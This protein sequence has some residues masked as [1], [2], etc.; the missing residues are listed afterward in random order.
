MRCAHFELDFSFEASTVKITDIGPAH[1]E[2]RTSLGV[3]A[4]RIPIAPGE[5][6]R[7]NGEG[8]L[9]LE[10]W[11]YR[12]DTTVSAGGR[13]TS[14]SRDGLPG[15]ATDPLRARLKFGEP[16]GGGVPVTLSL[17]PG[18]VVTPVGAGCNIAAYEPPFY[19]QA[20]WDYLYASQKTDEGRYVIKFTASGALSHFGPDNRHLELQD[21]YGPVTVTGSL[22]IV[23]RHVPLP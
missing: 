6:F 9:N 13:T 21:Q 22:D 1:S 17:D 14:C 19:R 10:N 5:D 3:D 15:H 16:T 23:L 8:S 2:E 11:Q 18:D 20:Y 7:M 12:E 4:E